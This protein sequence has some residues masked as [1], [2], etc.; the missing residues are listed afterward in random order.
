VAK[1]HFSLSAIA[2]AQRGRRAPVNPPPGTY[3]P[4]IDSTVRQNKRQYEDTSQ[5]FTVGQTRAQDD[6]AVALQQLGLSENR[7][8]E[9]LGVSRSRAAEDHSRSLSDLVLRYTRLGR[10]QAEGDRHA[11]VVSAGILSQQAAIRAANQARD[12]QPIDQAYSR[13]NE[14]AGRS[15]G[16]LQQ[17][18]G[19]RAQELN[20]D[21]SRLWDPKSGDNVIRL[22]RAGRDLQDANLDASGQRW[23]QATAGGYS[24]PKKKRRTLIV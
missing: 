17:D 5:D 8:M 4:V 10:S 7:N 20:L 22:Q 24:P 18:A 21:F 13:F 3:D 23:Y 16:R 11:G 1:T 14:D 15:Q 12:Q 2:R 9:D 19:S 6:L